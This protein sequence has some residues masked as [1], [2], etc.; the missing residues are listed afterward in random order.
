MFVDLKDLVWRRSMVCALTT[1]ELSKLTDPQMLFAKQ[2]ISDCP[3][4][5]AIILITA[6][7]V[8]TNC[9][10]NCHLGKSCGRQQAYK[11]EGRCGRLWTNAGAR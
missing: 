6:V 2:V 9:N 1:D 3:P 8:M 4:S 7:P 5:P 10:A 11:G